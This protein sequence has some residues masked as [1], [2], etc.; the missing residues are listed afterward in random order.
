[1]STANSPHP[2]EASL[3][4]DPDLLRYETQ[5]Y[6][7]TSRVVDALVLV[8]DVDGH[9]VWGCGEARGDRHPAPLRRR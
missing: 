9:G 5:T 6:F 2:P 8:K 4:L 3:V 1:M 7:P